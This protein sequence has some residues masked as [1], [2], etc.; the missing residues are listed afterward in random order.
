MTTM[1]QRRIT[2]GITT[3]DLLYIMELAPCR[4]H[5]STPIMDARHSVIPVDVRRN[6]PHVIECEC[7]INH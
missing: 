3:L 7:F 2:T 6:A 5:H 4:A 1:A